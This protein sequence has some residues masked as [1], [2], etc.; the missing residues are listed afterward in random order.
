MDESQFI[1]TLLKNDALKEESDPGRQGQSE[2]GRVFLN[3]YPKRDALR[4]EKEPH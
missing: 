4:E 2:G 1:N 3:E